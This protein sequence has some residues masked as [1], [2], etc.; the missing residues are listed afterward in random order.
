MV[1][2]KAQRFLWHFH[3]TELFAGRIERQRGSPLEARASDILSTGFASRF[4]MTMEV[5]IRRRAL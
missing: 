1:V 2:R 4:N 3:E 5:L